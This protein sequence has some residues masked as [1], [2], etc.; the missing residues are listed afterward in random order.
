MRC[1]M[2][3]TL[4][5]THGSGK[6]FVLGLAL[7]GALAAPAGAAV[8]T[9]PAERDKVVGQPI[10]LVVQPSQIDLV[11]SRAMQQIVVTGRY[12]DGTVRDLTPFSEI[13]STA[14]TIAEVGGLGFVQPKQDGVTALVVKAGKLEA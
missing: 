8:P 10:A 5:R 6:R 14:A 7:I 13:T 12:A 11:G 3:P 9:D 2:N 4:P 1:C